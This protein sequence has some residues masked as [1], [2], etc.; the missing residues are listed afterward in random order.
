M[1]SVSGVAVQW[2]YL[3]TTDT[4]TSTRFFI[5]F[6]PLVQLVLVFIRLFKRGILILFEH[7]A[8]ADR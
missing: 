4:T 8:I 2:R 1:I 5:L 6:D 7:Q 3:M